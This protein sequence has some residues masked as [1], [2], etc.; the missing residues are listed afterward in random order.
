MHRTKS[1]R[2]IETACVFLVG[3][4]VIIS[5]LTACAAVQPAPPPTRVIDTA[6]SWVKPITLSSKDILTSETAREIAEHNLAGE[7]NCGWKPLH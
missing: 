1:G 4:A 2:G 6:C 5:I 3:I 7:K